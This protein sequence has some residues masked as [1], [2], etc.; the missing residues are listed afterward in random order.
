M[1]PKPFRESPSWTPWTPF[2]DHLDD[3]SP[4]EK[5]SIDVGLQVFVQTWTMKVWLFQMRNGWAYGPSVPLIV[6]PLALWKCQ[7]HNIDIIATV[8][9]L[10]REHGTPI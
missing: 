8:L 1:E 3:S 7:G 6:S 10:Q 9:A 4:A 5:D 2:Y